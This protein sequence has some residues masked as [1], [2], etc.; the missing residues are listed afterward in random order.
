MRIPVVRV[1]MLLFANTGAILGVFHLGSPLMLPLEWRST[2][3]V[4]R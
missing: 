1:A 4:F 3:R 2:A